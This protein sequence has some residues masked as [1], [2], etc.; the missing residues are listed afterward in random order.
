MPDAGVLLVAA[1]HGVLVGFILRHGRQQ[2]LG[3]YLDYLVLNLS[4]DV[5]KQGIELTDH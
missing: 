2:L 5:T 3:Y 1:G 4:W